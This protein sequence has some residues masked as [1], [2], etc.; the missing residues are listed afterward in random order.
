MTEDKT[1]ARPLGGAYAK[2]PPGGALPQI[3]DDRFFAKTYPSGNKIDLRRGPTPDQIDIIDIAH[4][5]SMMCR[6]NGH[7]QRFYSIAE[8]SWYVSVLAPAMWRP[9]FLLHDACEYLYQDLSKPLKHA[10]G[11][12]DGP[13]RK[14]IYHVLSDQ[15]QKTIIETLGL[16][17]NKFNELYEQIKI[18]DKLV[19][20]MERKYI[21][22]SKF[23]IPEE[24]PL[25]GAPFGMEPEEA[26][27]HFLTAFED[28]MK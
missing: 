12:D 22:G 7:I 5:L 19:Y 23:V 20:Q 2:L 21:T 11:C 4:S 26:A 18:A 15:C 6:F 3:S 25:A 14:D 1:N 16:N 28:Y 17:W 13:E 9:Y 8:H 27:S 24:S 10:L